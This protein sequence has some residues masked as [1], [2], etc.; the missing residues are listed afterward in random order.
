MEKTKIIGQ[1]KRAH[2]DRVKAMA[3]FKGIVCPLIALSKETNGDV[4]KLEDA[5]HWSMTTAACSPKP[6]CGMVEVDAYRALKHAGTKVG[7]IAAK[8]AEDGKI[9]FS[10][11][12]CKVGDEFSKDVGILRAIN[13]KFKAIDELLASLPNWCYRGV[14]IYPNFV[15]MFPLTVAEQISRFLEKCTKYFKLA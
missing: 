7:Y 2:R 12:L 10:I 11:S 14:K 3:D 4:N 13:G 8:K 5:I 15:E 6:P 1:Y 9:L